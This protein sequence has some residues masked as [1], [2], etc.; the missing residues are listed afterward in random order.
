M[1]WSW[2][3]ASWGK[4]E[5]K[6]NAG[7]VLQEGDRMYHFLPSAL[8]GSVGRGATV[9]PLKVQVDKLDRYR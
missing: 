7:F 2:G 9:F 1:A 3:R 4:G 8:L 5:I 6:V